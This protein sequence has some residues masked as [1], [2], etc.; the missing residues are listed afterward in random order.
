[1]GYIIMAVLCIIATAVL[2]N[3]LIKAKCGLEYRRSGFL[4]ALIVISIFGVTFG[5]MI[6]LNPAPKLSGAWN[7]AIPIVD[8]L[9]YWVLMILLGGT[10]TRLLSQIVSGNFANPIFFLSRQLL[11]VVFGIIMSIIVFIVY[12]ILFGWR[13]LGVHPFPL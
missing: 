9:I 5:S 8:K 3:L 1:M 10:G 11:I 4:E 12:C 7:P 6:Y 2:I 13:V